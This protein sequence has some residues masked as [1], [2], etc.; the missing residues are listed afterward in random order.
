MA[1]SFGIHHLSFLGNVTLA[2]VTLSP[3]DIYNENA[4]RL[5]L[6]LYFSFLYLD[7]L[8][9]SF[10]MVS[11]RLST[12]PAADVKPD[13]KPTIS[14]SKNTKQTGSVG[15]KC[16]MRYKGRRSSKPKKKAKS[17]GWYIEV[18]KEQQQRSAIYTIVLTVS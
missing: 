7:F 15:R 11:T 1:S 14:S 18:R 5:S 16:G 2:A 12:V 4:R 17:K 10:I 8:T 6:F 13:I 9:S 3:D